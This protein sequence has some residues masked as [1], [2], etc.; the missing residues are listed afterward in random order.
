ME[1]RGR[2]RRP[3]FSYANVASTLALVFALSGSAYAVTQLPPESVGTNQLKQGAV[4][5]GKLSPRTV[6]MLK[7]PAPSIGPAGPVGPPGKEGP[8]GP[9]GERGPQGPPYPVYKA[10]VR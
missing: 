3:R 1:S 7:R 5:P 6:K 4:T 9:R 2:S 10:P 8:Q